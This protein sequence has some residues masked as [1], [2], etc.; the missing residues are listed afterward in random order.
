[1]DMHLSK[2]QNIVKGREAWHAA[3]IA[4]SWTQLSEWTACFEGYI[5]YIL[6]M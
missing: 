2:L 6:S 5:S 4:K 1:M 3:G